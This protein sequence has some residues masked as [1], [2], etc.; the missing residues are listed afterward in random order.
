MVHPEHKNHQTVVFEEIGGSISARDR[1]LMVSISPESIVVKM[2]TALLQRD[3]QPQAM[4][5]ADGFMKLA[6]EAAAFYG[7]SYEKDD[8]E[9]TLTAPNIDELNSK[10]KLLTDKAGVND[11]IFIAYDGLSF[12]PHKYLEHLSR[13]EIPISQTLE[14]AA[15]DI[16]VHAFGYGVMSQAVF[17]TLVKTA[18]NALQSGD[19]HKIED[20]ARVA[21]FTSAKI[22]HRGG[23]LQTEDYT[24]TYSY[25]RDKSYLV[26]S[27]KMAL[28]VKAQ[29]KTM[30]RIH[31]YL[32]ASS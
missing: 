25:L 12:T 11:G 29:C 4:H 18:R 10:K 32:A 6:P 22:T 7:Y 9:A 15:H 30:D 1:G 13:G 23:L 24:D 17:N 16:A 31:R 19:R 5:Y 8:L 14:G 3:I 21:D 20:A 2:G 26:S 28:D 27:I